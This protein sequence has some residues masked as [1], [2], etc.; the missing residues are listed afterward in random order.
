MDS[1]SCSGSQSKV[2]VEG[3]D[4]VSDSS[5]ERSLLSKSLLLK[6]LVLLDL[7]DGYSSWSESDLSLLAISSLGVAR[8]A[9]HA[10][11]LGA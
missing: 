1:V 8:L 2:R 9:L 10:L 3:S 7:S 6:F 4:L 11:H 5:D